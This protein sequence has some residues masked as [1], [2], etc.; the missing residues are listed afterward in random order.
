MSQRYHSPNGRVIVF[1]EFYLG[2][3]EDPQLYAAFPLHE[4]EKSDEGNWVMN[5]A[6]EEPQWQTIVDPSTYGY[7]VR[8]YGRLTE[9]DEIIYRLKFGHLQQ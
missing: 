1:K 5:H 6:I 9:A 7:K 8:I 4:W 2:D 3:V